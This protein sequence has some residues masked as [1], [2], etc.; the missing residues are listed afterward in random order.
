[1]ADRIPLSVPV[2]EGNELEYLRACVEENWVAANGRF[3]GAFEEAFAARHCAPAAVSTGSGTAA[4]HTALVELGIGPGDEVI[5]PALTFV[6]SANPVRYV[7]AAPVFADVDPETLTLDPAVLPALCSEATRAIVVV[8]LYGH[9]A[10]MDPILAL[11]AERGLA[12]VEDATEALG[13]RYRDRPCGTLGDIGCFSFN[14]NKVI[15]TG[16]GGM[17]LASDPGRLEHMRYLTLQAREPGSREYL[18]GDV[19]FNY[20]LSNLHAA[21]GLAQLERFDELLEARR[22]IAER[23]ANGLEGVEGLRHVG[24]APWARANRWLNSVVVDAEHYGEDREALLSRL[25]G[26]GIEARPFFHPLHRLAPY[27]PF[28]RGEL[29]RADRLHAN[30]LNLPSSAALAPTEQDRVISALRRS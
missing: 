9:P 8:H 19:G 14:G 1:M 26:E 13:S 21:V 27:A 24:E 30:G 16:G 23:Y 4:L 11:A 6:A 10:D 5:V 18:H 7:G 3:V 28:A 29:P 15:T 2:L 20:L 22:R 17:L 25:N 12:V